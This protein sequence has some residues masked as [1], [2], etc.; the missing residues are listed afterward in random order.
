MIKQRQYSLIALSYAEALFRVARSQ[1]TLQQVFDECRVLESVIGRTSDRLIHFFGN[2]QLP[3]ET[4]MELIDKV[5]TPRFGPPLI[6]M[7]RLLVERERI[8]YLSETLARVQELIDRH[9]GIEPA[10]V[11]SAVELDA[12][13][14]LQ[15]KSSLERYAGCRLKLEF[16]VDPNL[17]GGVIFRYRDTL[18]DGSLRSG[19]D[20]LRR[21]MLRAPLA[22]A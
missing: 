12:D 10:M 5:L 22:T 20:A 18:V 7:V 6:R 16:E 11:A 9:A 15:L 2:P 13:D 3:T 21:R 1:D 19:L 8:D 17:I 4:K 14:K